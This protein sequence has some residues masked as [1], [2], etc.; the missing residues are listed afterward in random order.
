MDI[1]FLRLV[2]IVNIPDI[3]CRVVFFDA[4]QSQLVTHLPQ[5][6]KAGGK[7]YTDLRGGRLIFKG[8]RIEALEARV[9]DRRRQRET[10]LK[11]R[12]EA[13][14]FIVAAG[15]FNS[16]AFLLQNGLGK[17]LPALGRYFI[18]NPSVFSHALFDEDVLQWRNIPA[19]FGVDQFR[20]ARFEGDKYIEGGYLLMPN[21][22][23]PGLLS[24]TI[25]GIGAKHREWM[26]QL[27]RVGGTIGWL[28]DHPEELGQ[29]K[30]EGGIRKVHYPIGPRTAAM[31]RDLLKKQ[32]RLSFA[33]GAKKVTLGA[34]KQILL[35]S[36]DDI[37]IIDSLPVE[38]PGFLMQ[39]APHP[40]GGCRMGKDPEQSVTN[41]RHQV[42]GIQ[43]LYVSDSSVFPT[44]PSVDPSYTI[45][46][47]SYRLAEMLM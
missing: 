12:I 41:S 7:I 34:L 24:A 27:R 6:L 8:D 39:A 23:Q 26:T 11:I 28:D 13:E 30:L 42:H 10:S 45:M 14:I 32:V 29:I 40:A 5:F 44:G 20:L 9:L 37:K 16:S 15:G 25:P 3:V 19:A 31:M 33:A 22:L 18:M 36:M 38:K 47:F 43:N 21:Q 46:A 1:E 4:K 17:K 2:K 35:R